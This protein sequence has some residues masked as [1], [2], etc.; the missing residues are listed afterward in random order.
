MV[1]KSQDIKTEHGIKIWPDRPFR[2]IGVR[3]V[4]A[5]QI[6]RHLPQES[7]TPFLHSTLHKLFDVTLLMLS[8][9]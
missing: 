8:D 2:P 1:A 3:L 6:Q 5:A 4:K 7:S 9:R